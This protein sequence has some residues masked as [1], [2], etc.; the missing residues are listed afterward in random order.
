M[1]AV[2]AF[3]LRRVPTAADAEDI[4]SETFL[5]AWRRFDEAPGDL[6]PWLFGVA[7]HVLRHHYR[8]AQRRDALSAR[9]AGALAT[10]GP[11]RRSRLARR[12]APALSE[13][14]RDVLTLTAW[15]G[16]SHAEAGRVLGCSAAAVAVRLHRAR[17]RL[18]ALRPDAATPGSGSSKERRT[19]HDDPIAQL[20]ALDPA[21]EKELDEL[22]AGLP[23]VGP[24]A[25]RGA[26]AAAP[27]LPRSRCSRPPARRPRV[28]LVALV[29]N[30]FSGS[31]TISSAEAK[32]QVADALDLAG[33]LARLAHPPV[34]Q[35]HEGSGSAT[36]QWSKPL[37]EDVWHAPDG[38]LVITSTNGAGESSTWLYAGGERRSYDTY[39]N[40]LTI[41]RFVLPADLRDEM[42]T[43]LPPSATD[44]YRAAYRVGKVRLAGIETVGGRRVYRLAFD[45]L[46]SSY[47]L[48][49]DADRKVPISSQTRTPNGPVAGA[50]KRY[51]FTRVRYAA[52]RRVQPGERPR[53]PPGAAADPGQRQDR[54]GATDRRSGARRAAH[55]RGSSCARRRRQVQERLRTEDPACACD[56]LDRP[57]APGRRARR[58]R[59]HPEQRTR[60]RV[61]RGRGRVRAPGGRGAP[62]HRRLRGPRRRVRHLRQPGRQGPDRVGQRPRCA[63]ARIRVR[64]RNGRARRDAR[65]Q[66]SSRRP[67]APSSKSRRRSWSRSATAPSSA[68]PGPLPVRRRFRHAAAG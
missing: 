54:A 55:P 41:H 38:R 30:P 58:S 36:P 61:L 35:R 26:A 49:F 10:L 19:M 5:V 63:R 39:D 22:V 43:Y 57:A 52:Y 14:D 9:L 3:A 17:L 12:G 45:W 15:E 27:A 48:V 20:R 34:Q 64:G 37:T 7:R 29:A 18:E 67:R 33:R 2:A 46:G 65:R 66:R 44:L 16:L 62:G 42:R 51:F 6:R 56:L 31:G 24:L 47:T 21:D 40:T 50:P 32:A 59:P 11:A 8:A 28:V 13:G 25:P 60:N 23:G 68:G 53:S 1:R 4:V